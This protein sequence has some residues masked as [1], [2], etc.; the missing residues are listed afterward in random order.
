[1][2]MYVYL[3]IYGAYTHMHMCRSV[4]ACSV[5]DAVYSFCSLDHHY[6]V[7]GKTRLGKRSQ[8]AVV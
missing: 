4:Y 8:L 3:Y 1:M 6:R 7:L 5:S 2:H